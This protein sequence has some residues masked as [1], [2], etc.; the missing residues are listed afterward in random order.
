VKARKKW[1]ETM[2]PLIW[3]RQKRFSVSSPAMFHTRQC[4]SNNSCIV[5]SRRP[6]HQHKNCAKDFQQAKLLSFSE[7]LV[8][9]FLFKKT[10]FY[11][12]HIEKRA[13][14]W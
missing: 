1:H 14:L 4:K 12:L 13:I 2:Q 9:T 8:P 10:E 5:A 11:S 7:F 6:N 3:M